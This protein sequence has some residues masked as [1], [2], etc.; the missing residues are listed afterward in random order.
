MKRIKIA[1]LIFATTIACNLK[2]QTCSFEF[3]KTEANSGFKM[4]G[5]WIWCGSAIKVDS[6]YHLFA[7]RWPKRGPFPEGYRTNSEIVHATSKSPSGPYKFEEVVIGEREGNFWD[8]NMAHNPTI[9][10]IGNEYVL[11]YIGSDFTTLQNNSGSLLRRVGYAKSKS[12][13]GP[14]KRSDKPLIE[15]ES[16]NPAILIEKNCVKLMYRDAKLKVHLAQSN[17]Y[18]GPFNILNENIWP[19]APLEDFYLF[20]F[21]HQYHLICEDNNGS[22]SGHVKWGVHVYSSDGINDWQKYNPVIAYN[23]DIE[24]SNG[25]ILHC[26]RRERPQLIIENSAITYLITSVYDGTNSWSQPVKLKNALQIE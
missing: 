17:S 7:S 10:K 11:F 24:L 13:G 18:E 8:S 6:M 1:M 3:E 15:T 2:S 14:W 23:H 5:Y 16:N 9:H 20:K 21:N 26:N 12:I 4:D 25:N 22:V 19:E